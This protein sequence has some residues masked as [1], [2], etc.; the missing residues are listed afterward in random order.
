VLRNVFGPNRNE[1]TGDW[2]TLHK[3]ELGFS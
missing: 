2:R 1:V 3:E